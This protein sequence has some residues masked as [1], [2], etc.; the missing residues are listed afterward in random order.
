MLLLSQTTME[1]WTLVSTSGV[2]HTADYVFY[3]ILNYDD[4]ILVGIKLSLPLDTGDNVLVGH[5]RWWVR[6]ELSPSALSGLEAS[7]HV[8]PRC[9][10]VHRML[11]GVDESQHTCSGVPAWVQSPGAHLSFHSSPRLMC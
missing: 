3:C 4:H 10:F 7:A 1:A 8:C 2:L 5:V 11:P 6:Y 9:L